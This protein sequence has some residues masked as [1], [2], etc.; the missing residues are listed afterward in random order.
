MQTAVT[1]RLWPVHQD[2]EQR[3]HKGLVLSQSL[4]MTLVARSHR[5]DLGH[6]LHELHDRVEVVVVAS[7]RVAQEAVLQFR[8]L[9]H[10]QLA[11]VGVV[12]LQ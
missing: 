8:E 2:V 4:R 1:T 3:L 12:D 5:R 9:L 11:N 6:L 10:R 7:L